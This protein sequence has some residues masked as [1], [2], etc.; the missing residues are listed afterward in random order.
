VD[1]RILDAHVRALSSACSAA[2]SFRMVERQHVGREHGPIEV[3][4]VAV[5]LEAATRNRRVVLDGG[6]E[7]LFGGLARHQASSVASRVASLSG[8]VAVRC[9]SSPSQLV[10][11]RCR[12]LSQ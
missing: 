3:E 8:A 1:R 10:T 11:A 4:A 7:S 6:F 5:T 12:S 9:R 2:S